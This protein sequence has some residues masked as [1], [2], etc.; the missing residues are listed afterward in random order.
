[1]SGPSRLR[2]WQREPLV[3]FIAL[4]LLLLLVQRVQRAL[5]PRPADRSAVIEIGRAEVQGVRADL[6]RRLGR[7]P[8]AAELDAA[9]ARLVDDEVLLREARRRGLD[10]GDVIVRRRL[11]QKMEILAEALS[12]PLPPPSDEELR[13]LRDRKPERFREP[14]RVALEHVFVSRDRHGARAAAAAESLRQRLVAGAE[15][16]ELGE[17]FPRGRSFGPLTEAQLAGIFGAELARAAMALPQGTWS[18]PLPSSYGLHLV[19]VSAREEPR[20]P[21]V[22]EQRERLTAAFHEARREERQ[23]RAIEALRSRYS[24]RLPASDAPGRE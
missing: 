24:V 21:E 23:R 16:A 10:Q 4:G 14:G 22:A 17:P 12:P 1:L 18:A 3:H 7:A 2:A 11:I 8:T 9:L 20:L 19:R 13:A 6:A 5:S 15:A